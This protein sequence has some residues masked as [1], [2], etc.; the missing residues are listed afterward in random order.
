[1]ENV[2]WIA[3]MAG[4]ITLTHYRT[5]TPL[6]P[7]RKFF[8]VLTLISVIQTAD[9][10]HLSVKRYI[11]YLLFP[12]VILFFYYIAGHGDL[13][14][15]LTLKFYVYSI[16]FYLM[17][18]RLALIR[19]DKARHLTIYVILV[20]MGTFVIIELLKIGPAI[21]SGVTRHILAQRLTVDGDA[22]VFIL[23]FPGLAMYAILS[24]SL[25]DMKNIKLKTSSII[26]QFL[27]L[28]ACLI[29][30]FTAPVIMYIGGFLVLLQLYLLA[31]GKS[32]R[33]VSWLLA[34]MISIAL[35]VQCYM[36][37]PKEVQE[38]PHIRRVG[39]IVDLFTGQ[40]ADFQYLDEMTNGRIGLALR[41]LQVFLE[42][43]IVGIGAF[44]K[45]EIGSHSFILDTLAY[46]GVFGAV[47]LFM[48]FGHWI[49]SGIYNIRNSEFN[50]SMLGTT[51]ACLSIVIF[52]ALNPYLFHSRMDHFIFLA[53]GMICGD[54]YM[55][56]RW[57]RSRRRRA[58]YKEFN[59]FD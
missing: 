23:Y 53:A 17:G 19:A 37:S 30:A 44:Y 35:F 28:I 25:Y 58:V 50:W 42:N 21:F 31:S 5:Q 59:S 41:S 2:V 52:S 14:H 29:S 3:S 55:L 45:S 12:L 27:F 13:K 15:V 22:H 46:Y 56:K 20:G 7:I 40:E 34:L 32:I 4:L 16:P 38:V 18:F 33:T 6:A 57:K 39:M 43:P 9:W 26:F 36:S 51:A 8:L 11:G 10:L 1:V 54:N 49:S 24:V 48:L 47:P